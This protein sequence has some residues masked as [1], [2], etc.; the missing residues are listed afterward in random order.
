MD[1]LLQR[2]VC[3][4]A[5]YVSARPGAC[6]TPDG[7]CRWWL[8]APEESETTV[9]QALNWLVQQGA[10]ERLQAA[11]GRVRYRACTDAGS[12]SELAAIC[13]GDSGSRH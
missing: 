9:T 2:F 11:D 5:I 10:F 1:L 6:D 13:S 8:M 4:L 3:D 7:I 12:L